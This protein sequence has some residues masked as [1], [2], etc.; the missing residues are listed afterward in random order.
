MECKDHDIS[1]VFDVSI[2]C[3]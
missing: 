3:W 2:S 1:P